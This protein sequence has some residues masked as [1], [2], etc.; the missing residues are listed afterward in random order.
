MFD[1]KK[2]ESA[3]I[4]R[5]VSV[6]TAWWSDHIRGKHSKE[7]LEK[8]RRQLNDILTERLKENGGNFRIS[9]TEYPSGDLIAAASGTEIDILR[10][11]PKDTGLIVSYN[12]II[13]TSRSFYPTTI[14]QAES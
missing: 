10:D 11:F 9:A 2:R 5:C 4:P 7:D 6:A 12:T 3:Q 13:A 8:F 1:S 14:W